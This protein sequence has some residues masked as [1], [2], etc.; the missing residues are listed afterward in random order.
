VRRWALLALLAGTA[1]ADTELLPDATLHLEG[2]HYAP[3]DEDFTWTGW[4][5]GGVGIVRFGRTTLDASADL[6]TIIGTERRPFDPNQVAYHLEVGA[7]ISAG[8]F[9]LNPVFHHVSRHAIDAPHVE[10]LAWNVLG[11]RVSSSL[12]HVGPV[13]GDYQV[14]VGHTTQDAG[15]GYGWEFAAALDA[16]LHRWSGGEVYFAALLRGVTAQPTEIYDRGSFADF[17][18]ESGARFARH[19]RR[20]DLFVQYEHRNDVALRGAGARDWALFGLRFGAGARSFPTLTP[21]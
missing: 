10:A 16:S 13:T 7:R 20:I 2:A 8:R 3:A 18:A 17:A 11:V 6:D 19:G 4:I 9:T 21:R 12:P 15:T 5:G 14:S 1:A